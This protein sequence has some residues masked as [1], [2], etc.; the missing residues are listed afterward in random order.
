MFP[1]IY[2]EDWREQVFNTNIRRASV[3]L[4]MFPVRGVISHHAIRASEQVPSG[5]GLDERFCPWP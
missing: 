1:Q 5:S 3:A 4:L 2:N